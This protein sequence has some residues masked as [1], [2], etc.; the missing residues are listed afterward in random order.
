MAPVRSSATT[1]SLSASSA[2]A[3]RAC[4]PRPPPVK[5]Q[6]HVSLSRKFFSRATARS[7]P[8]TRTLGGTR[9]FRV[10]SGSVESGTSLSYFLKA[11]PTKLFRKPAELGIVSHLRNVQSTRSTYRARRVVEPSRWPCGIVFL[12]SDGVFCAR[13][14]V[15]HVSRSSAE[16]ALRVLPKESTVS[17]AAVDFGLQTAKIALKGGGSL[18]EGSI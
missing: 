13:K 14:T 8:S 11:I 6:G 4:A 2:P 3:S 16:A 1:H 7:P 15:P 9:P 10:R 5:P 12:D 18:C 17:V